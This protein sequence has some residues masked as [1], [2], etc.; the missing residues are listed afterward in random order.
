MVFMNCIKLSLRCRNDAFVYL[1]LEGKA[2]AN[3]TDILT[4]DKDTISF[5]PDGIVEITLEAWKGVI[6]RIK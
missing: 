6:L 5:V 2:K 4:G 1:G 3:A